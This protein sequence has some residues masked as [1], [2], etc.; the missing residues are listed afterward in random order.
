MKRR[1]DFAIVGAQK[2][3]TTALHAFLSVHP[4]I[5]M[6]ES[7]EMHFFNRA[8]WIDF[9]LPLWKHRKQGL[10]H[11]RFP[12]FP[13]PPFTYGEATPHY[14]TWNVA[15]DRLFAYNP[16]LRV[17]VLLRPPVDRAYS[18][19]NMERQRGLVQGSFDEAVLRELRE[20]KAVGERLDK[21]NS[22][23]RRGFYVPQIQALR[24][25]FGDKHVLV[26]KHADL[27]LQHNQT[28]SRVFAFLELPP[29]S[30]PPKSVHGRSYESNM[31]PTTR[32]NLLQMYRADIEGVERL[33]GWDCADWKV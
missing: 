33:L 24:H 27:L 28:L 19:W 6:P 11:G 8:S 9:R 1:I 32:A 21:V 30:V 12:N 17:I 5:S 13:D 14:M 4:N 29:A 18:H 2:S 10:Y 7:K 23:L 26:L 20:S 22:F 31:S 16:Q 25:R 3:G 15:L